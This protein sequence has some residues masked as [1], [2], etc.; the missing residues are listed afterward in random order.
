MRN[1]LKSA[2]LSTILFFGGLFGLQKA[3]AQIPSGPN[4]PTVT[5]PEPENAHRVGAYYVVTP[6]N[7]NKISGGALVGFAR[8]LTNKANIVD[9]RVYASWNFA[10]TGNLSLYFGASLGREQNLTEKSHFNYL[11][12]TALA[13]YAFNDQTGAYA[14]LGMDQNFT[15]TFLGVGFSHTLKTQKENPKFSQNVW[16]EYDSFTQ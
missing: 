2:L 14:V 16:L 3:Q 5:T 13:Y 6:N 4:I 8:D 15:K 7:E 9:S 10:N 11:G 1:L 12:L